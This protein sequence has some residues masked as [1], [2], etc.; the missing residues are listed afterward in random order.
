MHRIFDFSLV[1]NYQSLSILGNWNERLVALVPIPGVR[2]LVARNLTV[3]KLINDVMDQ[4]KVERFLWE[5]A[6]WSKVAIHLL[7]DE[8]MVGLHAIIA[9]V[10]IMV[11][12]SVTMLMPVLVSMIVIMTMFF[13]RL[14]PMPVLV[15]MPVLMSMT[16]IVSMGMI[17]F[18]K[19]VFFDL[20]WLDK[21]FISHNIALTR[22][23]TIHTSISH[24]V[25]WRYYRLFHFWGKF[26]LGHYYRLFASLDSLDS[27][28]IWL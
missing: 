4:L 22:F 24:I 3:L 20:F 8:R 16:I 26:T 28:I 12:V 19:L 6:A 21:S 27:L 2:I 5:G 14:V 15:S 9:D 11:L 25:P 23:D 1:L 7:L 10:S 17:I 18:S 13:F